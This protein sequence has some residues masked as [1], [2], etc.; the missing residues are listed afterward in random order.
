MPRNKEDKYVDLYRNDEMNQSFKEFG[1]YFKSNAYAVK[2]LKEFEE[3]PRNDYS[4]GGILNLKATVLDAQKN[5][6]FAAMSEKVNEVLQ[7]ALLTDDERTLTEDEKNHLVDD[8]V[9]IQLEFRKDTAITALAKNRTDSK[10]AYDQA[11]DFERDEYLPFRKLEAAVYMAEAATNT[12]MFDIQSNNFTDDFPNTKVTIYE[13]LAQHLNPDRIE[14]DEKLMK[15]KIDLMKVQAREAELKAQAEREAAAIDEEQRQ[16]KEDYLREAAAEKEFNQQLKKGTKELAGIED[17]IDMGGLHFVMRDESEPKPDHTGKNTQSELEEFAEAAIPYWNEHLNSGHRTADQK[18]EF[19]SD[20][21]GHS[22]QEMYHSPE[23]VKAVND[24]LNEKAETILEANLLTKTEQ[25]YSPADKRKIVDARIPNI[26]IDGKYLAEQVDYDMSQPRL[27]THARMEAATRI[28]EIKL[29][30]S[31]RIGLNNDF[32]VMHPAAIRKY[33]DLTGTELKK[34][35]S[36]EIAKEPC[37]TPFVSPEFS[38][39]LTKME[40][41]KRTFL[42][43]TLNNSEKYNAVVNSLRAIE[44]AKLHNMEPGSDKMLKLY[45]QLNES[46]QAYKE[47]KGTSR[48]TDSGDRRLG[49]VNDVEKLAKRE[50]ASALETMKPYVEKKAKD[51][52]Y[53]VNQRAGERVKA[54]DLMDNQKAP[55]AS[56]AQ[57]APEKV[58][59][60]VNDHAL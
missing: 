21:I 4:V 60:K 38:N 15:E 57:K 54:S 58:K 28:A 50:M 27:N 12:K 45:S 33:E 47:G 5:K 13:G 43:V 40:N 29:D 8:R 25:G 42:G 16:I 19:L 44:E 17:E 46:C 52:F 39:M 41:D 56:K 34:A 6:D 51:N 48:S 18:Y 31:P 36:I 1:E 32:P 14:K 22:H 35:S 30:H 23:E 2:A 53:G 11:F 24:R 20:I 10:D 59:E 7:N 37:T 55:A 49:M 26:K 9:K 3:I